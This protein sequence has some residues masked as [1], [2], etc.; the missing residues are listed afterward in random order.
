[1][2]PALTYL[3]TLLTAWSR[4]LLEQLTGSQL[5]KKFSA[6]YGSR[7]F[8]YKCPYL[9]PDQSNPEPIPFLK[10]PFLISPSDLRLGFSS[11]LFPSCYPTTTLYTPLLSPTFATYPPILSFSMDHQNNI[12]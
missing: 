2:F 11:G 7:K 3:F 1:M 10:I 12:L 9:E 6:F 4:V 5:I 8:V